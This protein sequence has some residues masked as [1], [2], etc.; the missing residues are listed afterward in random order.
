MIHVYYN[1]QIVL[2]KEGENIQK[3]FNLTK[4]IK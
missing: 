4:I 1:G 3:E 2:Y